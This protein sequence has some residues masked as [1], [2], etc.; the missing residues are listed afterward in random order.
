MKLIFAILICVTGVVIAQDRGNAVSLTLEMDRGVYLAESDANVYLRATV[1]NRQ[2]DS[3]SER[4]PLNIC[5]VIDRSG[6]M[7]GERIEYA[8]KSV[9]EAF[10]KLSQEDVFSLITYGSDVKFM[11]EA[12]RVSDV[13]SVS[14][15]VQEIEAEGGSAMYDALNQAAAQVRRLKHEEGINRVVFLT[16]GLATKGP[17]EF[18]D[19]TRL[20]DLFALEGISLSTIGLGDE[21]DEDLLAKLAKIGKGNFYFLQTPDKL[22]S[23]F[24]GEIEQMKQLI[25]RGISLEIDFTRYF[26]PRD[27]FGRE[28]DLD[29]RKVRIEFGNL[30]AGQKLEAIISVQG[31]GV[32][33]FG[34]EQDFATARLEWDQNIKGD[35]FRRLEDV[36]LKFSLTRSTAVS[37]RSINL[38]VIQSALLYQVSE[39]MEDALEKADRGNLNY[40]IRDLKETAQELR[41]LNF[42]YEDEVIEGLHLQLTAFAERME[43]R[44][45]NRIDRKLIRLKIFNTQSQSMSEEDE[46]E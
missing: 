11:V 29:G 5:F 20:A 18:E 45:L 34:G 26:L 6:S 39:E 30:Y 35:E 15:L 37:K 14:T 33:S 21:F 17:R 4:K 28:G 38:S 42:D 3:V 27:V 40:A 10:T 8:R 31:M 46:G 25:A 36:D 41:R 9:L 44:G 7:A 22:A 12:S 43:Q 19:F 32:Q 16:D 1:E 24:I 13:N 2:F 23:S